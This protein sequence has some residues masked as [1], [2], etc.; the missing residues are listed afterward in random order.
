MLVL[1]WEAKYNLMTYG[2]QGSHQM[3]KACFHQKTGF[4]WFVNIGLCLLAGQFSLI[5]ADLPWRL[6]CGGEFR[7]ANFTMTSAPSILSIEGD[8]EENTSTL[9]AIR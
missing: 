7:S 8:E 4:L 3:K 5:R 9:H 2:L 6:S 1:D